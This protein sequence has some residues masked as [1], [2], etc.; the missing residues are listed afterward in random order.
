M[1]NEELALWEQIALGAIIVALM[2]YLFPRIKGAKQR[3]DESDQPND[4]MSVLVPI[5]IVVLFV[6]VLVQLA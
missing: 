3:S 4:W 2:F 1:G 5:G 6:I